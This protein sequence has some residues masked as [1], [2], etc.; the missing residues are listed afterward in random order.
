MNFVVPVFAAAVAT[1]VMDVIILVLL[2]LLCVL[3]ICFDDLLVVSF[4]W[5]CN[6]AIVLVI[7]VVMNIVN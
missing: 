3:A 5:V 6:A 7:F 4:I 1:V 2:L